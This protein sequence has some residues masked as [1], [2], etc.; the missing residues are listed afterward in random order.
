MFVLAAPRILHR[1]FFFKL[2][3][4]VGGESSGPVAGSPSMVVG[5][6]PSSAN[7][8]YQHSIGTEGS[9][10]RLSKSHLLAKAEAGLMSLEE[11]WNS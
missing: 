5:G 1:V 9:E 4:A 2:N 10:G 3:F 8:G 11:L 7:G 6:P